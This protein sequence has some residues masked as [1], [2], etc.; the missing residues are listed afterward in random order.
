MTRAYKYEG[1]FFL[2]SARA[3]QPRR[4]YAERAA[5]VGEGLNG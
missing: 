4:M 3:D 2:M 5:K 1:T